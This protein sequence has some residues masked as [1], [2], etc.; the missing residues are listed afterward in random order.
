MAGAAWTTTGGGGPAT[1]AARPAPQRLPTD[2]PPTDPF[3]WPA[4]PADPLPEL[5][6]EPPAA[7]GPVPG[8]PLSGRSA[9]G[10]APWRPAP[11]V[12]PW[13]AADPGEAA[14]LAAAFAV[15]Y[16]SWDE[17]DAPR[18]GQV[19]AGYLHA[20][21][22]DPA[23][24]G[25]GGRGRQR[26]ELAIPGRIS[27]DGGRLL[28]DVRVRVTPY[29]SV[30]T[31][32]RAAAAAELPFT[33]AVAPAPAA[34]GWRASAS[35]WVRLT[36]PIVRDGHR[37]VVDEWTAPATEERPAPAAEER[38]ADVIDDDPLR[39]PPAGVEP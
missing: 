4:V 25:W 39:G 7:A 21:G 11:G 22:D 32:E 5:A 36:I 34:R 9:A 37:L 33:P 29:V 23:Y 38:R 3:G 15:D 31:P 17:G 2:D 24:L 19:L 13:P 10:P 1:R 20:P 14:G 26:A 28:V 12:A 30:G 6:A 35:R 16:L 18:R 8:G 27:A